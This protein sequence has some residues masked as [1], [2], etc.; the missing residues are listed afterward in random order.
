MGFR[1][2]ASSAA[3]SSSS[4]KTSPMLSSPPPPPPTTSGRGTLSRPKLTVGGGVH[5]GVLGGVVHLVQEAVVGG[6]ET[7]TA[8]S[9][10]RPRTHPLGSRA[11]AVGYPRPGHPLPPQQQRNRLGSKQHAQPGR[12]AQRPPA[13]PRPNRTRSRDPDRQLTLF[14]SRRQ[15]PQTRSRDISWKHRR[16]LHQ[17]VRSASRL[18]GACSPHSPAGS[19]HLLH[20]QLGLLK[21]VKAGSSA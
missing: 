7:A 15:T 5:G 10:R 1:P 11:H 16:L 20:T 19:M 9:R 8:P 6:R 21:T 3:W 12:A 2:Q 13:I 4:K 14:D 17:K 18:L